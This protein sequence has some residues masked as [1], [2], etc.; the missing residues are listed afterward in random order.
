MTGFAL[1]RLPHATYATLVQQ[2]QGEPDPG[3]QLLGFWLTGNRHF[4]G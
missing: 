1:Y 3:G 4:G 2:T